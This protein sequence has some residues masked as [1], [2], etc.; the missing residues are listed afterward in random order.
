[1]NKLVTGKILKFL[2]ISKAN[3]SSEMH[4]ALLPEFSKHS[5]DCSLILTDMRGQ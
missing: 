5:M 3:D 4:V 1:M 2:V